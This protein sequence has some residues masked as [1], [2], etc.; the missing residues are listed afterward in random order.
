M[1]KEIKK[2]AGKQYIKY[3]RIWFIIV[4]ILAAIFLV[5][6]VGK[7]LVSGK[8]R[9][10]S[11]APAERVYDYAEVL[12]EDEEN[13]LRDYIAKC[14][15]KNHFDIVLVTVSEDM[16]AKSYSWENAM[17]TFADDFYDQNNYG[18]DVVHGDG[19]LLLDNW[20]EGQKG[21]W[22]STCGSVYHKFGDYEIDD[23]LDEVD[24]RIDESP[25][26]AY[27]AYVTETCY[28][29]NQGD[30]SI[31]WSIILFVPIIVAVAY[32]LANLKQ[33][34][35]RDTTNSKTYVVNTP[36][37]NVKTDEFVRKNVVT[38][39]IDTSSSGGGSSHRSSGGGGGHR[40]SG[41][42]SHGGGGHRR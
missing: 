18:Y 12:T 9:G 33:T 3:F 37:M 23:V 36:V 25:Y 35:A 13:D 2:E 16:E 24:Y 8:A 21:S 14:E 1:D 6:T 22:L 7:A 27:K 30:V 15:K 5:I 11:Q 40:S 31:P 20:F 28:L 19:V 10:N 34:A 41:G 17:M 32:A 42:V 29:M 38:R 39:H 26:Q 4:G